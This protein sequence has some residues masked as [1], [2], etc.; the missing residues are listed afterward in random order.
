MPLPE[1]LLRRNREWSESVRRSDPDL[2]A[3]LVR[4]QRPKYLWIGC[5]DS[6][7][8]ANQIIGLMPGEVFVHRN[9]ANLVNEGDLNVL[10][11]LQFAI[12]VLRVE[13]II[14]CGHY[15]CGGIAAAFEEGGSEILDAWLQGVRRHLRREHAALEPLDPAQRIDRM[16]QLNVVEQVS[17]LCGTHVVQRAWQQGQRLQVHGAIYALNDGILHDLGVSIASD[18]RA[19]DTVRRTRKRIRAS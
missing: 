5:S 16:C 1:E 12:A 2:F 11:V 17:K 9:V 13:H 15:G 14:V 10:A 8:P 19:S 3:R 6:R 7:V 18:E 4:Q